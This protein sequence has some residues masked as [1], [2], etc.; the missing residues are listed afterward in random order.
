MVGPE[1]GGAAVVAAVGTA[2]SVAAVRS[3]GR[4]G[5]HVVAVSEQRAPP[6]FSSRYCG[7]TRR[8]PSPAEDLDGYADALLALAARDDVE[9]IVPVREADV[10]VLAKHREA[11]AEHLR[12]PWPSFDRLQDVHDRRRLFAAAERAGVP[13][14][15]TELL[16]EVDNWD[17]E[18]IVKARY[19]ILTADTVD[20]VSPGRS[21]APPKT[22]FLEPGVEPDVDALVEAMGHVPIA[23]AY[24]DGT[25]YCFRGL[26]RDGEPVVTSQKRLRRGYKYAR[27]PSVYHEAVDDPELEATGRAL[28]A[29]LDWEGLA[30]VGFIENDAGEFELLEVN[31]RI[32]ASVPVDVHAGVD[33][34]ARYWELAR[35]CAVTQATDYRPGTASHLLRG[36][37][38]HLHSIVREDYPLAERPTFSGAAWNVASSLVLQPRFDLLSL[39]DPGPFVRDTLNTVKSVVGRD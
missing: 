21:V 36:E 32:P 1:P 22:V 18:R 27:G 37:L 24:V 38:V 6:S 11:F 2:G 26:Y 33:Y 31:P 4:H 12:T 5:V 9:A 30:S 16:D 39:D 34:P 29:E 25:E 8:V 3:L 35:E 15:D 14:P 23:Q 13:A 10:H 28:L 7:E 20:D 19:A 17:R